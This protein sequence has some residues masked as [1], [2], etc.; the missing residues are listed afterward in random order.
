MMSRDV[1]VARL[2][3]ALGVEVERRVGEQHWACCPHP[4]HIDRTPSWFMRE[5]P[6]DRFH[7]SFH[8]FGCQF[9]GRPVQLVC[10]LRGCTQS[11]A[12][13]WLREMPAL[14]HPVPKRV[15]VVSQTRSVLPGMHA[16]RVPDEV[17]FDWDEPGA[18]RYREYL[19]G[20]D[21]TASQVEAWGLGYVPNDDS[22]LADRVWIPVRDGD[23]RLLSYT[24]RAVASRASRAKRRYREPFDREGARKD[25]VFGEANWAHCKHAVVVVCEGAFN[26]LAVER[27][28][29]PDIAIAALM[30]S[31]VDALQLLKLQRFERVVVATDP[32]RA[33][34]KA[35][36]KLSSMLA[37]Y[38]R[39]QSMA[40]PDGQDCDSMPADELSALLGSVL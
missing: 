20:R 40:L 11:E 9:S 31:S 7:A 18:R 14:E 30:G 39:V 37:R 16:L 13:E 10:T 5:R 22:S 4:D 2:L 34:R 19:E 12:Y 36:N 26:A 29:P 24:A 8:C 17:R 27:I 32:D 21:V 33:G 35:S 15:E 28:A 25:A 23:G 38:A 1:D 6:G 3:S